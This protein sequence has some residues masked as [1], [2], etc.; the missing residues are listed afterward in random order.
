MN[1]AVCGKEATT[2]CGH[3]GKDFCASHA[4][5]FKHEKETVAKHGPG[6][7]CEKKA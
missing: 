7:T 5:S 1:C 6:V 4:T 3:C 2:K